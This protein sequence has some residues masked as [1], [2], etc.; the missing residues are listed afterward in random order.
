MSP[1]LFP[2]ASPGE[3]QRERERERERD[4]KRERGIERERERE[5][6]RGKEKQNNEVAQLNQSDI[7]RQYLDRKSTRL[8][9]SH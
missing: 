4:R 6:E 8:N 7:N 1:Y 3:R 2:L 5:R 9:S